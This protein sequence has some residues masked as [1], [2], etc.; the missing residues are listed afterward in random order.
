MFYKYYLPFI[1]LST[2]SASPINSGSDS[3]ICPTK[4]QCSDLTNPCKCYCSHE[5]D[6]RDKKPEEDSPVFVADDPDGKYCYC[7]QWDLDNFYLCK[8]KEKVAKE[9]ENAPWHVVKELLDKGIVT[10]KPTSTFKTEEVAKELEELAMPSEG[11][12]YAATELVKKGI[13]RLRPS[14]TPK[15]KAIE[16]K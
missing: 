8:S 14:S 7:K 15:R 3:S 11:I 13:A 1:L 5:C 12:G 16:T 10:L 2:F 6:P 4:G 9:L